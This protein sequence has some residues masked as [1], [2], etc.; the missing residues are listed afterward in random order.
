MSTSV[1]AL[2]E[3][4]QNMREIG[5]DLLVSEARKE[6]I[7]VFR[8]SGLIEVIGRENIFPDV[9]QNP[10]LSTARALRRAKDLVGGV[11]AQVRIFAPKSGTGSSSE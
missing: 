2:M 8:N 11:S 3:L 6:V 10:T 1:F 5:R 4:V 7:R 9:T